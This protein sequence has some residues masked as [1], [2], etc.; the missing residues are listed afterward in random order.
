MNRRVTV[1]ACGHGIGDHAT[2]AHCSVHECKCS[3]FVFA[4][5]VLVDVRAPAPIGPAHYTKSSIQPLDVIDAWELNFRRG[6]AVKYIARAPHKG[7]E[8]DD[9]KKA[10]HYLDLEIER[11]ECSK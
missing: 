11:M 2:D 6:N 5:S 1:C 9:L 4:G 10:R 8:L 3:L 7:T